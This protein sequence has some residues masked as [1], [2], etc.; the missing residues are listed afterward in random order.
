MSY[1][2]QTEDPDDRV[3]PGCMGMGVNSRIALYRMLSRRKINARLSAWAKRNWK[4]LLLYKK[5]ISSDKNK[6]ARS[7]LNRDRE[8]YVTAKESA[9]A[10]IKQELEKCESDQDID[11]YYAT[12]S[13]KALE[14]KIFKIDDQILL[15]DDQIRELDDKIEET[16]E[17]AA[18]LN[19]ADDELG[20][21]EED[22]SLND[23]LA[24]HNKDTKQKE[25]L[26]NTNSKKSNENARIEF[27]LRLTEKAKQRKAESEKRDKLKSKTTQDRQTELRAKFAVGK[28]TTMHTG[29]EN[30]ADN[31][32]GVHD[33]AKN[34]NPENQ[35]I[36]V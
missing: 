19:Q 22:D 26:L 29:A 9:E 20:H 13:Y 15:L 5:Q 4:Q 32:A 35:A 1:T 23:Y 8:K 30:S 31:G 36:N 6:L 28:M 14:K 7:R 2:A 17:N 3:A 34:D 18:M 12:E 21:V 33:H 25:K 27:E 16:E 24:V 10:K 11:D